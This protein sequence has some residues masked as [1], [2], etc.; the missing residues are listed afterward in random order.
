[1]IF[2]ENRCLKSGAGF[3]GIMLYP[4]HR[5]VA[6]LRTKSRQDFMQLRMIC[7]YAQSVVV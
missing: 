6:K 4:A 3:F 1:M 7:K 2:S 5:I